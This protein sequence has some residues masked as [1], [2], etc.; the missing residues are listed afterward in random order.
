MAHTTCKHVTFV[1]SS[2]WEYP[3]LWLKQVYF[4]KKDLDLVFSHQDAE[5]LEVMKAVVDGK[6]CLVMV[7]VKIHRNTEEKLVVQERLLY[8]ENVVALSCQPFQ[9]PGGE[10]MKF[11]DDSS[12]EVD[13]KPGSP[14]DPIPEY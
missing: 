2:S 10:F 8:E 12:G 13:N 9:R 14:S 1:D 4:Y 6:E 5:A 11:G 3:S 7:G